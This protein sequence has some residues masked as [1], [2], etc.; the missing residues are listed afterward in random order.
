MYMMKGLIKREFYGDGYTFPEDDPGGVFQEWIEP[1]T[2]IR[3]GNY[4]LVQVDGDEILQYNLY[5]RDDGLL[6]HV[7]VLHKLSLKELQITLIYDDKK[8]LQRIEP[9]VIN[10]GNGNM[11]EIGLP[12]VL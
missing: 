6:D 11:G 10:E 12:N 5:F 4:R 9:E 2:L 1:Y 3:D 7:N 8:M